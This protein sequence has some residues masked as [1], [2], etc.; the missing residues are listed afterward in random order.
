MHA[1]PLTQCG[2]ADRFQAPF[3]PVTP[4]HR[5]GLHFG[6]EMGKK[7][8]TR[9]SQPMNRYKADLRDFNFLLFEQFGLGELLSKAPFSEWDEATCREVLG[10]V[11]RF[12]QDV[13][14]PLN[15]IGDTHGCKLEN[16]K[17]TTPPGFKEAWAKVYEAGWRTIGSPEE[18]GG[19]ASPASLAILADELLSGSNTAFNMYPGLTLGA[20]EVIAEFGTDEEKK[21][22]VTKLMDGTWAGTMC[23]T[24]PHAGSDVGSSTTTATP[25]GD[26]TYKIKGTKIFISGGEQDI[27]ENIIHLVLARIEGAVEGT[28]GLSLF[29]VPKNKLNA[30]GTSGESNDVVCPSI[31]HKM[32]INGQA[33]CVLNFGDEDNCIGELVGTVEHQGMRQMFKLMN[34]AR[35][36]VGIQGVA[37]ASS[38]Y[39]NA[40]EYARDRKQGSSIKDWKDPSAPR[41][42]IIEHPNIR[43]DLL[44]MKAKV[45]GMRA[46]IVKLAM[47]Q[48]RLTAIGD[49]DDAGKA[50]HKGQ[51][52]LLTPLVKAYSSDE[53]YKVCETAI[54]VYGGAGYL[55]DW[56]VEQYARDSKIFSIYEGTNAIQSLDLVGRKLGQAGGKN[57]QT[58]LGDIQKFIA[59]KAEDPIL[60]DSVANLKK[61]HEAVGG[62]VMQFL[63]WFQGGK[64]GNIPLMAERFLHMMSKL[65]IGWLLLEGAVIA[66]EK[67]DAGIESDAE[68]AFYEGKKFAAI[69][70]ANNIV[71]ECIG[72]AK[73]LRACDQ[74]PVQMSDLA[75]GPA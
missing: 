21:T 60:K 44:E 69:Y 46:L 43:R 28:K 59:A 19:M 8:E 15:Q 54:Q 11:Y 74:S 1:V 62:S 50:Y 33:T 14:G 35:I 38:A 16:G 7:E 32:G 13:T 68:K 18:Y 10:Q 6:T 64:M 73:I 58:F 75:F 23:L 27:T 39:L 65:A 17:V 30:D 61:A 4:V 5:A 49:S 3:L 31:E 26:G 24:E 52:D 72:A 47:H 71:P 42:A 55:K 2:S 34:F 36:G 40:L 22:F 48:D 9:V 67:L 66:M 25:L 45:E 70:Y 41:A 37:V 12:A 56:P 57:T 51:V 29:I 20:A 63:G 53:A